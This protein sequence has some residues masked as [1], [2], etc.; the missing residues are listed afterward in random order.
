[1]GRTEVV[2]AAEPE[3][4]VT[5]PHPLIVVPLLVKAT[6]PVGEFPVTVAVKTTGDPTSLG[7]TLELSDTAEL[8]RTL[9]VRTLD[10][11]A[12]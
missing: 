8:N 1:M 5:A 9:W 3:L 2:Q 7:L 12:E 4:N 6:V 11:L 10:S